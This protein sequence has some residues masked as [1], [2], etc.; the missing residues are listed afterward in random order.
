MTRYQLAKVL[1][2]RM[3]RGDYL[4][5]SEISSARG[6]EP[7]KVIDIIRS[8]FLVPVEYDSNSRCYYMTEESRHDYNNRR[9][10]Q[11]SAKQI[12]DDEKRMKRSARHHVEWLNGARSIEYM[13]FIEQEEQR[14]NKANV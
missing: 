12:Q 11:R 7:S 9:C 14:K 13:A 8:K 6:D 10:E 3:V 4:K 2:A 1:L 5:K